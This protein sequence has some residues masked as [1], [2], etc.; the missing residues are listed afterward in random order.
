VRVRDVLDQTT[1][2]HKLVIVGDAAMHPGELLGSGEWEYYASAGAREGENM[3]G[4]RWLGLLQDHFR[5]S[6]WLNPDEPRY[7]RG[8]T[9]EAI[10]KI[11]PMYALTLDGLGEAVAHLSKGVPSLR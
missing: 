2:D 8:G 5:R 3:P 6:V 10:G 1:P 9:A 7:W 4:V 11:F